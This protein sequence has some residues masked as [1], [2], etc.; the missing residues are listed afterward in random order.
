ASAQTSK[1]LQAHLAGAVE[2]RAS[3][4]HVH[5]GA[6]IKIRVNGEFVD[7]ESDPLRPEQAEA[8]LISCM[9][10]EQKETF[11]KAG[12]IDFACAIPEVGRFRVNLYRQQR[13]MDGV[14]RI[15]PLAPPTL[16][17]LGLPSTLA[18]VVN[19][20]Q[21]LVLLTGPSGCGKSSTLAALVGILNEERR[22]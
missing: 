22:D 17:E 1:E 5:S 3:D 19:Y 15:I 16:E 13:G 20:H 7:Q 14:F 8:M 18:R 11:D 2:A 10:P 6:P 21:G 4:L 12:E 9:T